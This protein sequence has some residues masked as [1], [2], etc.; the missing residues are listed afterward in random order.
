MWSISN[1]FCPVN[2]D[3]LKLSCKTE[4]D[5][6]YSPIKGWIPHQNVNINIINASV[7]IIISLSLKYFFC[8]FFFQ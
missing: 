2:A 1:E 7:D 5:N 6:C 3:N 8:L 4:P